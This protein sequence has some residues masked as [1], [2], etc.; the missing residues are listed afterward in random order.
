MLPADELTALAESIAD[1]GLL[2]PI[3]LTPDDQLLDGRN[4]AAACEIAGVEPTTVIYTADPVA[5]VLARNDQRRHMTK[6]QRAM[7]AWMTAAVGND[8]PPSARSLAT[9]I[10]VDRRM[11]DWARTVA[12]H[13]PDLA[14]VVIAGAT[15][16]K[17]AYDEARRRRDV[18]C[19]EQARLA[20]LPPDLAD[21]VREESLT[22]PEAEAAGHA[23]AA[24]QAR[25]RRDGVAAADRIR[26]LLTSDVATVIG[27][28]DLGED[29][30]RIELCD[31]LLNAADAL[32]GTTS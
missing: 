2:E 1:I 30:D 24:E 15:P 13:A 22:L 6:G 7:A 21:Q 14:P 10:E 26:T 4:R 20:K 18:A 8:S 12:E 27:A 23:R 28:I 17:A 29:I 16:L 31:V 9:E 19:G 11:V 3:V 25:D 32:K 5:Y